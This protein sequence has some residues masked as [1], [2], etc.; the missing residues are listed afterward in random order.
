M[1]KNG[2]REKTGENPY[3][4]S[5]RRSAVSSSQPRN[6]AETPITKAQKKKG[7]L[8]NFRAFVVNCCAFELILYSGY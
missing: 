1:V 6:D 8:S 2:E 5:V 3:A 4:V 7:I